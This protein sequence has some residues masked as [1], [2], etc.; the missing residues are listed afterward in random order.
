MPQAE[1]SFYFHHAYQDWDVL[2][3][4]ELACVH[5]RKRDQSAKIQVHSMMGGYVAL[6]VMSATHFARELE[7]ASRVNKVEP[8]RDC[9]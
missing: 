8:V 5:C 9:V 4:Q 7:G 6:F 2:E 3:Y 1:C